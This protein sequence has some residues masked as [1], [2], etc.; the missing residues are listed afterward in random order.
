MAKD[1][2]CVRIININEIDLNLYP[3]DFDLTMAILLANADGSVYHRYGGRTHLSPMTMDGLVDIMERGLETHRDYLKNPTPAPPRNPPFIPNQPGEKLGK[4]MPRVTGCFHCHYAREARQ[5]ILLED[6]EWTPDKFWIYPPPERLGLVMDQIRQYRVSQVIPKSAA[7]R[8]GVVAGDAIQTLAGK[9]VLT[10]Y[11]IQW[12][13]D[14]YGGG[15]IEIPFSLARNKTENRSGVFFLK[16]GWKA[17]NPKDE[18]WRVANP[19]TA[20]MIKF[21][22]APGLLGESLKPDELGKLGLKENQFALRVT[23][24]NYGPHQ[25]GIRVGDVILGAAGRTDFSTIGEFYAW[26]EELRQSGRDIR[27]QL[28]REG[29]ELAIMVSLTYLN[30]AKMERAPRVDLGFTPQQLSANRGVRVGQIREKGSA[31]NAGFKTGD[32]VVKIDGLP[33]PDRE[34]LLTV[35]GQ[36]SPGELVMFDLTREGKPLQLSY[37]LPGEDQVRSDLAVLS[38][39]VTRNGQHNKCRISIHLPSGRHIY[40]VHKDGI[41][42]PTR[43]DFR[44]KGFRLI[45][46]MKEPRPTKDPHG[47]WIHEGEVELEQE[48]E[49]TSVE[50]FE[51]QIRISAQVCDDKSCHR[52]RAQLHNTGEREFY[53][54]HGD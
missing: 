39:K 2:V 5:L 51:M 46:K 44:G 1:Y 18:S 45:G 23:T 28:R 25:A 17:G 26:C 41:G 21:L 29:S 50:N 12:Q 11:D 54:M 27:I 15:A 16:T 19:F 53:E 48:F 38:E 49:V 35:V 7:D 6:G 32:H 40:S 47:D 9:R 36:K 33:V 14:Q 34:K 30:Y 42:L 22:P 31:E 3:F 13:L 37:I 20:H 43:A 10:K 52:L 24:L 4:I 8:A